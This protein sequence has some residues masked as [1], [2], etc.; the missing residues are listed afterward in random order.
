MGLGSGAQW[1]RI[2]QSCLLPMEDYS[3]THKEF[4][5]PDQA[6]TTLGFKFN[7]QFTENAEDRQTY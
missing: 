7:Y 6:L 5:P 2:L 3:A 1:L 4:M